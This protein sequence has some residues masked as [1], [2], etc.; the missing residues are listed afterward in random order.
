MAIWHLDY[1]KH[2]PLQPVEKLG[3]HSC[4]GS[5]R[6]QLTRKS[7]SGSEMATSI[8]INR[9]IHKVHCAHITQMIKSAKSD[10]VVSELD[11]VIPFVE[12]PLTEA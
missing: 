5:A 9:Y 4:N 1:D 12:W 3:V 6:R 10:Y 7:S 11:D 2:A 8:Q